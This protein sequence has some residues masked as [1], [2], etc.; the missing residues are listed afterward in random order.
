MN[1]K[2]LANGFLFGVRVG[3]AINGKTNDIAIHDILKQLSDIASGVSTIQSTGAELNMQFPELAN[4]VE[5]LTKG[6]VSHDQILA[7][8]LHD[9]IRLRMTPV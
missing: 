1:T 6:N 2:D 3:N 7:K 5:P 4:I 9:Q 8:T